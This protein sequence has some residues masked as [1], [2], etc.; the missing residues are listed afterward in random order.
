[1][2]IAR[3]TLYEDMAHQ[4]IEEAPHYVTAITDMADHKEVISY[5]DIYTANGIKLITKN[6]TIGGSQREG[7]IKHKLC[8]PIDQ[9]L[10]VQNGVTVDSLAREVTRLIK[11]NS[12]LQ[13]LAAFNGDLRV[14][15]QELVLLVLSPH[16]AFKLT[17][18]KEQ[19]PHLFQH[20]V[21]VI[22][23]AT[24][25]QYVKNCQEQTWKICCV[26]PCFMIWESFISTLH[27]LNSTN[28]LSETER[29]HIYAHSIAGFLIVREVAGI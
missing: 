21:L 12:N 1:M 6:T 11:E 20:L 25:W 7:L 29:C 5:E 2:T 4:S 23:I 19:H 13:Y 16:M 14:L 8:K 15:P 10:I 3:N 22:L 26:Q 18:A 27:L 9:S 17:V 28:H 24:I